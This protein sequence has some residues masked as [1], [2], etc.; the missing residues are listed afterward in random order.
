MTGLRQEC[1]YY[2]MLGV[3]PVEFGLLVLEI[4]P[5]RAAMT[6]YLVHDRGHTSVTSGARTSVKSGTDHYLSPHHHPL[7]RDEDVL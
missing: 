1:S 3:G 4:G 2:Y 5:A 6:E 7:L